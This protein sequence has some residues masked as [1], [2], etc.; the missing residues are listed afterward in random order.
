M[1][2]NMNFTMPPVLQWGEH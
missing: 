2:M 1:N